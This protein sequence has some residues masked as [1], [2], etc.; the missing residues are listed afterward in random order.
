MKTN[1]TTIGWREWLGL[2]QFNIEA[3]KAKIDT[4]ARTSAIHAYYVKTFTEQGQPWV[5]FGLHPQQMST[6]TE[7]E[8]VAPLWD[9]RKVTDSGGHSEL[10]YVIRTQIAV[11]EHNWEAEVTLTDRETMK[12]RMLLGRTA[13]ADRFLVDPNASFLLGGNEKSFTGSKSNQ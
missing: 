1:K 4:G 7:I 8:C 10:R 9:Q 11:G 2:P 12:F 3:V 13:M 5:A 6:E